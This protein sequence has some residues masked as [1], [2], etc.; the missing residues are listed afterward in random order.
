MRQLLFERDARGALLRAEALARLERRLGVLGA[1]GGDRALDLRLP[2]LGGPIDR[3]L[4]EP[5]V[6][7]GEQ[8]DDRE[9]GKRQRER[10]RRGPFHSQATKKTM[11]ITAAPARSSIRRPSGSAAARWGAG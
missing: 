3:D 6:R 8:T 7:A 10:H 11:N 9:R 4:R 2:G 5:D 1:A